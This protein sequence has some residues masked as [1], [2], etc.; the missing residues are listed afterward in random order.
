[1]A[2]IESLLHQA[3]VIRDATAEKENTALR[4]GS[5]FVSFIQ[6]VM[7][8]MPPEVIDATGISCSASS[9]NVIITYKTLNADGEECERH[10]TI[11][12]V[13]S[14]RAGLM[15]PTKLAEINEAVGIVA[16]AVE[17]A[18]RAETTATEANTAANTALRTAGSAATDAA[19]AVTL[20]TRLEEAVGT[21]RAAVALLTPEKVADEATMEA[22]IKDG[23]YT[24]GQ[25]YY[26]EEED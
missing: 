19:S 10:I 18:Y 5:M 26:T 21:M 14:E 22:M 23:T 11:P 16:S 13:S 24:P 17:S 7:D 6:A 8:T 9:S 25:I 1:M 4:V 12:T 20:A 3:A 2:K 15:T